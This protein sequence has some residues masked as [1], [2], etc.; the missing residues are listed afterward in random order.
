MCARMMASMQHPHP[1][2]Q[3]RMPQMPQ[4]SLFPGMMMPSLEQS[5]EMASYLTPPTQ[6]MEVTFED[7]EGHQWRGSSDENMP[8]LFPQ[9]IAQLLGLGLERP[10]LPM[11]PMALATEGPIEIPIEMSP[12]PQPLAIKQAEHPCR[13]E[14][15]RCNGSGAS[16]RS[17][18]QCCLASHWDLLSGTCKAFMHQVLDRDVLEKLEHR[19]AP[20]SFFQIFG[21]QPDDSRHGEPETFLRFARGEPFAHGHMPPRVRALCMLFLPAI[22]LLSALLM[23]RH[24][25]SMSHGTHPQFVA[26]VEPEP[27]TIKT[28]LEPIVAHAMAKSYPKTL[29]AA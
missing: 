14:V 12:R 11:V 28:G 1:Q 9:A 23:L 15:E 26:F 3:L 2:P 13:V 7:S 21:P 29:Q 4:P 25:M 5:E 16:S 20:P 18:V 10:G 17:E 27:A 22:F 24:R 6:H 8:V 19:D